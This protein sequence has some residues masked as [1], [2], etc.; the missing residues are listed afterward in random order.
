MNCGICK[1]LLEVVDVCDLING[2][3]CV[4]NGSFDVGIYYDWY[5]LFDV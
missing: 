2:D 3:K 1:C 4:C 5:S